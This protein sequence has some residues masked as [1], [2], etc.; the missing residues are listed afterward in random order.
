MVA[1]GED[2]KYLLRKKGYSMSDVARKLGITPQVVQRVIMGLDKSQRV[3][4]Y[5]E[6]LLGLEPGSLEISREKRD[7]LV[8][9]A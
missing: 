4:T 2:L 1:D 6:T 3:K 7:A 9:A 5:V 8:G